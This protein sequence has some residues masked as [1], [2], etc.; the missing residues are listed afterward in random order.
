MSRDVHFDEDASW[1]WENTDKS[2]MR[3]PM[4]AESQMADCGERQQQVEVCEPSQILDTSTQA[5]GGMTLQDEEILE[6]SQ[7]IDHTLKKWKS[8]NEIMAQC[9]M[10]IVEPENFEEADLDESWRRA[11][12]AELEM[13]EKNNT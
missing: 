13:I 11:M 4:V 5:D 9:N 6:G 7:A 3:V 8:I 1:K 10:C 2:E 12:E